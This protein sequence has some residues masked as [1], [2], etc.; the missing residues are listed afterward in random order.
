MTAK[1]EEGLNA[2][3][4]PTPVAENDQVE[5][6]QNNSNDANIMSAHDDEGTRLADRTAGR[7]DSVPR[8]PCRATLR[9][10]SSSSNLDDPTLVSSPGPTL[11]QIGELAR[12]LYHTNAVDHSLTS[13]P[14]CS[15]PNLTTSNSPM[16]FSS[17]SNSPTAPVN[18]LTAAETD[19]LE[20]L[21]EPERTREWL[22]YT[23]TTKGCSC[24][25]DLAIAR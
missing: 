23:R 13:T 25:P 5:M 22:V 12:M 1:T 4:S 24:L 10:L 8:E 17:H 18:Q 9:K 14:G 20:S 21:P 15:V 3:P 7:A 11:V 6:H 2:N 16:N 19:I